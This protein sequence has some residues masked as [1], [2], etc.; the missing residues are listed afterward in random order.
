MKKKIAIPF[1]LFSVLCFGQLEHTYDNSNV[2]R[3]VLE[4][5]GEKYYIFNRAA[6][7]IEFYNADHTPWKYVPL[8]LPAQNFSLQVGEV[9]ETKIN[10]DNNIE[11]SYSI[12]SS[13]AYQ[14][15]IVNETGAVLLA[16]DNCKALLYN[17]IVGLPNKIL[18]ANGSVYTV[19]GLVLEHQYVNGEVMRVALENAGEK[20]CVFDRAIGEVRFYHADHSF[21]KTIALDLPGS[22]YFTF[23]EVFSEHQVN[24]D[25]LIEIGY[26]YSGGALPA[27]RIINENGEA[28][29]TAD[30]ATRLR[31]N[32][33]SGA[34]NVIFA[35]RTPDIN[36]P[37]TVVTDVYSCPELT[38][39]QTYQGYAQ[40]TNLE[41]SGAKYYIERSNPETTQ[42][43]VYNIDHTL[44]KTL[45]VPIETPWQSV[46]GVSLSEN[47][48]DA[49]NDLDFV[50][51]ISSN[52]LDG[53]HYTSNVVHE[54]GTVLLS[55]NHAYAAA[56]S[57]FPGLPIKLLAQIQDGPTFDNL[58]YESRVYN[59]NGPFAVADFTKHSVRLA[60]V[61][62]HDFVHVVSTATI[63]MW[64]VLDLHGRTVTNAFGSAVSTI[65][66]R[67]LEPG[68]YI[69][70]LTDDHGLSYTQKI[71]ITR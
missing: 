34:Q 26:G 50:Y 16:V 69:L 31:L 24:T 43:T 17:E 14:S 1:L 62:A 13:G 60:P 19:P 51:T 52:T 6:S 47:K 7:R 11:I 64:R 56:L 5:S 33:I 63:V 67:S 68:I 23:M 58:H 36:S 35:D 55:I 28:L 4:N 61:P 38:L 65:D 41:N 10:P 59:L 71:T 66:V 30:N 57:E 2:S 70:V 22:S 29:L 44:W 40:R 48:I 8:T 53:G 39:E 25:D 12:Y 32:H 37:M 20:Y 49:D 45:A 42:I 54:D 21:W 3:I 18:G 9:S 15:K 27:S 46:E